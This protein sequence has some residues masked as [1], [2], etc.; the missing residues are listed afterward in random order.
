[1]GWFPGFKWLSSISPTIERLP[2]R[3][4]ATQF[5][6]TSGWTLGS[7]LELPWLQSTTMFVGRF[8]CASCRSASA[9]LTA[10]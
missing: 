10:S 6:A 5:S 1:M 8:A 3:I 4:W 7:L 2:S 9:M